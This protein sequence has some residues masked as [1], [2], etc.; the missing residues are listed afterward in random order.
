[1]VKVS[2]KT[3]KIKDDT[4]ENINVFIGELRKEL[5]RPVS[6]DE[7]L[8]YLLKITKNKK[9][10]PSQFAGG[11]KMGEN[12]VKEFKKELKESWKRWEL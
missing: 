6:V 11:W 10:R 9:I 7:A 1:M 3:I 8:K 5:K 4:Y 2:F 12:E